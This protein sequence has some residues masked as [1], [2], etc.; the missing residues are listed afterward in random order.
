MDQCSG[1]VTGLD[2]GDKY[3]YLYVLDEVGDVVD[4]GRVRTTREALRERFEGETP[5]RVVLEVG[6][7]SR[8]V[9]AL[10][11]ALGHEVF[12]A[13][14]RKV[15]LISEG[16]RKSDRVDAKLLARLGRADPELLSPIQHRG[17]TA[18]AALGLVK[19][20][21][22][23]VAARTQLI[24]HVRGIVK[25]TGDRLP[26]C[27]TKCFHRLVDELP[28][29]LV[30][31]LSP[32]M[33]MVESQNLQI[34]GFDEMIDRVSRES[35]PETEGLQQVAG[36]GPVTALAFVT[37]L[38]DPERFETSRAVGAYLGLVPRRDQSGKVDKQL[39][40]T[41]AGDAFLRQLLVNAAQYILGPFGPDTDLRRWGNRLCE[42]GGPA[43]KK[44]A[45]VA[46]ARKLAVLLHRLWRTG[47]LYDPLYN[48]RR[49]GE[50]GV[51]D[52][53]C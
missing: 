32:V 22:A 18:Q 46:V 43:A 47:E 1:W 33:S 52:E 5:M 39:P 49:R 4:E 23:L 11:T 8:W 53:A 35:F 34:R 3:S 26:S 38:E 36:V 42:R 19:S 40:I 41:K 45:V 29:A 14:A 30:P 50:I 48:A 9:S 10:L 16:D 12:V 2:L 44:R 24:N 20:R 15:K 37:T 21:S 13:N 6:T 17:E 51:A 27:S 25:A 28:E 31:T 7:H